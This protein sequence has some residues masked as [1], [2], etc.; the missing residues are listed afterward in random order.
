MLGGGGEQPQRKIVVFQP[1]VVNEKAKDELI[2]RTGAFKVKSLP[3]VNAVV[4]LAG[5]VSD[6]ALREHPL[7]LRV[8]Y[9]ELVSIVQ[10]TLPWGVDRIDAD[11]V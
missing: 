8:K 4:V 3:L 11:L 2:E 6:K 1:W 7:V 9:D 10:Q 5:K